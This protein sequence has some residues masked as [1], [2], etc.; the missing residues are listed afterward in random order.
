VSGILNFHL[1]FQFPEWNV[2]GDSQ[3]VTSFVQM[4]AGIVINGY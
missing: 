4:L 3:Y 1:G 2:K